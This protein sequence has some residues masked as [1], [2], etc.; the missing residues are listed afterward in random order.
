MLIKAFL[1]IGLSRAAL[2]QPRDCAADNCIRAVLATRPG[3][4]GFAQASAD[5]SSYLSAAGLAATARL[6][7]TTVWVLLESILLINRTSTKIATSLTTIPTI[8]TVFSTETDTSTASV[9]YI[10]NIPS[11]VL[12]RRDLS[13]PTYATACTKSATQYISA[14]SCLGVVPSPLTSVSPAFVSQDLQRCF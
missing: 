6:I 1:L 5:C 3:A 2:L 8:T 11:Y 10:T 13:L 7:D 14:C 4:H 9:F 12:M